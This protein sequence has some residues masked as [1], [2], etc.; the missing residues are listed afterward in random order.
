MVDTDM[1]RLQNLLSTIP[2]DLEMRK[3]RLTGRKK[4]YWMQP[5]D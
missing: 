3:V 4:E 1:I 2:N 5:I